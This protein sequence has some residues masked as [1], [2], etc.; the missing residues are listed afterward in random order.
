MDIP[1]AYDP[2]EAEDKIYK[3]W[4]ESGFFDPDKLPGERSEY[5][6]ISMP[7]PNVTGVLHL[8]HALEN[9]IMD[10]EC[11]YRRMKGKRAAIIPGTDHAAVATQAKVEKLLVEEGIKD[12]RK[13]LGREGL[14]KKIRE[15]A[16]SSKSTILKQIEKMGTSC[17]WGR[18]AYTFDEKRN[19]AVNEIFSRMYKDGLIYRGYRVVNWSVKG[20]STASDDELVYVERPAKLYTFKYSKDFPIA[21]STTRPE[22]KLGDTAVAVHPDDERYKEY[23]G[24]TIAAEVGAAKPLSIRIIADESVDPSFGTGAVGVTP[25]HSMIDFEM[26]EKHGLEIIQVIGADGKMTDEAGSYKGMSAEEARKK[27]VEWLKE[28][29]LMIS[30]EDITHNVATS[31]RF[32]DIVEVIPMEQWF[33]NVNKEISGRGKTLKQL[34]KD[35]VTIGHNGDPA[36]K[37]R[38]TPERFNQQYFSWIDNLR[39]WCI[40]RQIWWGHRIPVWYKGD[41]IYC[42]TE[43]PEGQG[44][45]QDP[46]TLDT[47]FSSGT[48]TFSTLGWPEKTEDMKNM[49]PTAWM[50]MGYEILFFWMARMILMS[51]YA[52]NDIPF[53]EVYIHGILRDKDGRKFSK[54]L[55]NGIDPIELCEKYGTDALR[56]ALV[57]GTT[58]G[59]DA[60]FYEEKVEASRNF[61]NKLWNIS[62]YILTTVKEPRLVEERPKARTLADR[63]IMKKLD[64]LT[65]EMDDAL[66]KDYMFSAGAEAIYEF[67]WHHFADW[68][69]EI[70]KIEKDKDDILLYG[71][72]MLLRLAH[73]YMPFVT[74]KIFCLTQSADCEDEGHKYLIVEKWPEP[75]AQTEA[76]EYDLET[77]KE[78]VINIRNLRAEN[79]VEPARRV[80]AI[81]ISPKAELLKENEDIIKGLARVGELE[82]SEKGD[83]PARSAS[84]VVAGVEIYL[85]LEG[86]IDIDKEKERLAKEIARL[87]NYAASQNKKLANRQFVDN[88]PEDV[89]G[90]ERDKLEEAE[91]DLKKLK[92]QFDN[93]N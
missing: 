49:H 12:P 37:I 89:V 70:A 52:L 47:W 40:S 62:R 23:V 91:Y 67:T 18:L 86:L 58:P 8:G 56:M 81:L 82:I 29:G 54:S 69:I 35:A 24:Q 45:E 71:L 51:C 76:D 83:K 84:T 53:K 68:Y 6:S 90:K 46:D 13:E 27:F 44:W 78:I 88:A 25:A 75:M 92:A 80:R 16:E 36:E 61:V 38:I 42:G 87:E 21:I 64:D 20:Q 77:I 32:G 59:N 66:G 63:W 4:K 2:K 50:Q 34:M 7:P 33:V 9:S 1:K 55:G 39:D 60:R 22:T 11:R 3:T 10:I 74:E 5:F 73:P 28:Q 65:K 30:E 85:P 14:L 72:N 79:K 41:K 48:W 15:Y 19:K 17:D 57:S 43:A 93:L 26:Y 31:D